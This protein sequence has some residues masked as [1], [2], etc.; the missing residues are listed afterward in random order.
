MR[1]GFFNAFFFF[2]FNS[3]LNI[4]LIGLD[5]Y[6]NDTYKGKIVEIK[7]GNKYDILVV[8]GIKKHLIPKISEFISNIDLPNKRIYIKYIKGLDLE[9]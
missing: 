6:D 1:L 2:K 7:K 3:Y 4:D 5:V 8:D 9:D